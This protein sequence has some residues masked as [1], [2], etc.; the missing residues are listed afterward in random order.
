MTVTVVLPDGAIEWLKFGARGVSSETIFGHLTGLPLTARPRAPLDPSDLRRCRLLLEHVP[1][2]RAELNRMNEVSKH[3]A[4]LVAR[5][6]E[7][8]VLMDEEAPDWR[9]EGGS[10]P[11]AYKLMLETEKA[12]AS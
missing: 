8:C 5:W 3:W 6:D 11:R 1:A 2:F 7:I 12:A 9:N 10:A 4:A